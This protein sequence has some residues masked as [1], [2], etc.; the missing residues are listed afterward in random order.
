M[1]PDDSDDNSV[2]KILHFIQGVG[3]LNEWTKG[4][5]TISILVEVHGSL[6][7]PPFCIPLYS[8]GHSGTTNVCYWTVIPH[9]EPTPVLNH[10]QW[11]GMLILRCPNVPI[12]KLPLSL[13]SRQYCNCKFTCPMWQL[14]TKFNDDTKCNTD[15]YFWLTESP[16]D[17]HLCRFIN[18]TIMLAWVDVTNHF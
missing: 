15:T 3:L 4:L 16:S 11:T 5:H 1:K 14:L 2:S 9:N 8:A 12:S 13:P 6:F 17:L 18:V 7:C 10:L